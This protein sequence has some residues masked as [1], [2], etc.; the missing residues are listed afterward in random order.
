MAHIGLVTPCVTVKSLG[1]NTADT[2]LFIISYTPISPEC[3]PKL[4]QVHNVAGG[5]DVVVVVV[6]GGVVVVVVVTS[7]IIDPVKSQFGVAQ[8]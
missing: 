8:E 2:V 5:S 3:P 4:V 1:T 7:Q 6:G